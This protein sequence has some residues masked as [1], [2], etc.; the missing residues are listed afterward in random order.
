MNTKYNLFAAM[1][2]STALI[3]CNHSGKLSEK[4]TAKILKKTEQFQRVSHSKS[5]AIGCQSDVFEVSKGAQINYETGAKVIVP[6]NAFVDENGNLVQGEVKLEFSEINDPASVIASGLPMCINVGGKTGY[7]ESGGM[8]EINAT[9]QGKKLQLAE[10]K[11]IEIQTMSNKPGDFNFYSFDA[12]DGKW[13]EQS[14]SDLSAQTSPNPVPTTNTRLTQVGDFIPDYVVAPPKPKEALST[15]L[16]FE[17]KIDNKS[18]YGI[19]NWGNLMWKFNDEEKSKKGEYDWLF[20]SRWE[21]MTI[22]NYN[23]RDGGFQITAKRNVLRKSADSITD[24]TVR[25]WT[26]LTKTVQ[27]TPVLFGQDYDQALTTY[28]TAFKKYE[29]RII[30]AENA[31]KLVDSRQAFIRAVSVQ[32]MGVYNWD[33][34]IKQSETLVLNAEYHVDGLYEDKDLPVVYMITGDR[35]DVITFYQSSMGNF[36]FNPT[37]PNTL[38]VIMPNDE[39]AILKT[40]EIS[41]TKL[42]KARRTKEIN[43]SLKPTGVFVTSTQ[44]LSKFISANS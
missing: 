29:D 2:L 3:A 13:V 33:R 15:D 26:T 31:A 25:K 12:A 30:K 4:K 41:P 20:K 37:Y 23:S 38:L 5:L 17:L 6:E 11:Q 27:I 36:A 21:S 9:Q 16:V 34:I 10:G 1:V 18:T 42:A 19:Q 24:K 32:S 7:F 35:R 14:K 39:I 40:T 43:L 44:D 8:F 28:N 22:T